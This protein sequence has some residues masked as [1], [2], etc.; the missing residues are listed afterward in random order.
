M[1]VVLAAACSDA[2]TDPRGVRIVD[3]S[4]GEFFW[5]AEEHVHRI[6]GVSPELLPCGE[7]EHA[8]YTY[9]W[10]R[11]VSVV[12]MCWDLD[13]SGG[14]TSSAWDRAVV[15]DRD[16]DCPQ[17]TRHDEAFECR[18]G[19][20]QSVDL[21]AH[22]AGIPGYSDM[23][24]LCLGDEPRPEVIDYDGHPNALD[25]LLDVACP[26]QYGQTDEPCLSI[27]D[28]CPDPG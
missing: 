9:R 20:C 17:L 24:L 25:H 7:D 4:G 15:C 26:G 11:F 16:E 22:P 6:A 12:G 13:G 28:E 8:D 14:W 21:E 1:V 2:D 18:A 10:N 23:V 5:T 19:F 27:P 3:Q